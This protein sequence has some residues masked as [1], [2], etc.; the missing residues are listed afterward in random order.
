MDGKTGSPEQS[1][2]G[3]SQSVVSIEKRAFLTKPKVTANDRYIRLSAVS[4]RVC[5]T[6]VTQNNRSSVRFVRRRKL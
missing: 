6:L 3:G 5:S 1:M 4:D 2:V